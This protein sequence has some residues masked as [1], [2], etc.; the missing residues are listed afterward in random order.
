M[1]SCA[2][3]CLPMFLCVSLREFFISSLKASIIFMSWDFKSLSCFSGM[4]G[5]VGI[6]VVGEL[7]SGIIKLHWV[8]LLMILSLPLA[9][10]YLWC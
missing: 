7:G 1:L 8:L 10:G 6:A 4:L 5:Y 9:S 2:G 3:T